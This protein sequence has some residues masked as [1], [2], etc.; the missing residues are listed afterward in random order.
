MLSFRLFG[1]PVRIEP[2]FWVTLAFIGGA[3]RANDAISM[4]L[5]LLFV[6]AG[7]I[8]IMVHEFGHALTVRKFGLYPAVTLV[9]FGGYA[10][11]SAGHLSRR[12]QFWI[13]A[14]GPI[15][16]FTFGILVLLLSSVLPISPDSYIRVFL[17]YL[18]L[19]SIIWAILNC[20]PIYPMDG[21][22]MLASIL[23]PQRERYVYL[24]GMLCAVLIGVAGL[25]VLNAWVLFL[26]M[27]YFAW[28]NWG[29][30]RLHR[31]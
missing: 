7:F 3:L 28:K 25:F 10:S 1:I 19:V 26:F 21:G 16:Q 12:R 6:L 29:D 17:G 23:G 4:F 15:A 24:T 18:V 20:L 9:A 11:Y 14:A 30:Y 13:T 2:W 31:E 5:V 22:Q 8:S 27:A